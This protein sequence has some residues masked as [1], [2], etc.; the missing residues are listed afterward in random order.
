MTRTPSVIMD[1]YNNAVVE[2]ICEKYSFSPIDA[3]ME[4]TSSEIHRML[5]IRNTKGGTSALLPYF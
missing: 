4:F 5:S 2:L 1:Y 3:F